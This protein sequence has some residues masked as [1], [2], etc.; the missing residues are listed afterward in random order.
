MK[1]KTFTSRGP[2]GRSQLP[3]LGPTTLVAYKARRLEEA[4]E[5]V[6]KK[7]KEGRSDGR[8]QRCEIGGEEVIYRAWK[9]ALAQGHQSSDYML[10]SRSRRDFQIWAQGRWASP[11]RPYQK[12]Y[13]EKNTGQGRWEGTI[14]P[15]TSC[16][17]LGV[18]P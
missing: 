15:I 2:K 13:A 12:P 9:T 11:S 4:E 6:R 18:A 7:G 1:G 3:T 8:E 17:H 16:A 14:A 10:A 5:E